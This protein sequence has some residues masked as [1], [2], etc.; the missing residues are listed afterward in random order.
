MDLFQKAM[1]KA[2]IQSNRYIYYF[3][4]VSEMS[5]EKFQEEF[6]TNDF[7]ILKIH[8]IEDIINYLVKM[9]GTVAVT[10]KFDELGIIV[11]DLNHLSNELSNENVNPKL[12]NQYMYKQM[13]IFMEK[14][15]EFTIDGVPVYLVGKVNLKDEV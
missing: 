12:R 11:N 4:V 8:R 6:K 5:D 1:I 7:T 13:Q 10:N 14:V 3:D 2:M 15:K 9:Y